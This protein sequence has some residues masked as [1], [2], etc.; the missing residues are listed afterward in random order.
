MTDCV[1]TAGLM[2]ALILPQE[3]NALFGEGIELIDGNNIPTL[4]QK[5]SSLKRGKVALGCEYYLRLRNVI[6]TIFYNTPEI[7]LSF[8]RC[9]L[10]IR[11][12]I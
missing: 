3:S 2:D 7:Y 11:V 9:S 6:I 4:N 12:N 8:E 1:R 10:F 5:K